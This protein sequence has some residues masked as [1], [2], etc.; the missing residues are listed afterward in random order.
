MPPSPSEAAARPIL[1]AVRVTHLTPAGSH[2]VTYVVLTSAQTAQRAQ[3]DKRA[4]RRWRTHLRSGK[5]V[6]GRT[7]VLTESQ[8]RDR[9]PRGARLRLAANVALPGRIRFFDDIS[10]RMYEAAVAWRRGSE[11]GIT[12]LREADAHRLTRA[13]LFRLG[14]KTPRTEV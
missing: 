8:I 7:Y 12:F 14:I 6:D 5:I 4:E 10:K 9:S 13:E 3:G 11:I 1:D 2:D